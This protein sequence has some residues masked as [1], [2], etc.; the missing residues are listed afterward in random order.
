MSHQNYA[1]AIIDFCIAKV[2]CIADTKQ[3]LKSDFQKPA[4]KIGQQTCILR[5]ILHPLTLEPF[6]AAQNKARNLPTA[7]PGTKHMIDSKLQ[8]VVMCLAN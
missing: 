8:D 4:Y 5:G 1:C 3:R 6:A 7:C 2:F